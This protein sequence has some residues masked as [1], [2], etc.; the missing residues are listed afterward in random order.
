[1]GRLTTKRSPG[2]RAASAFESLDFFFFLMINF[3]EK[4]ETWSHPWGLT[5]W[6][7]EHEAFRTPSVL[8]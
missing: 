7:A 1:M 3:N 2:D 5:V 8:P 6:G 4:E